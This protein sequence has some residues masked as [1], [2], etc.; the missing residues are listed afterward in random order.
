[1]NELAQERGGLFSEKPDRFPRV[2]GFGGVD[3]NDAHTDVEG[4]AIDHA[5]DFDRLGKGGFNR[6]Q[7]KSGNMEEE[8]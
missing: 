6:K 1:M 5:P 4:V 7:T 3:A 2:T 8:K